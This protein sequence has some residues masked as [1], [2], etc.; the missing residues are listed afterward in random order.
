M[1][2]YDFIVIGSGPAGS[3]CSRLLSENNFKVLLLEKYKTPRK[4]P[5]AG[6]LS[7]HI[8]KLLDFDITETIDSIS[9]STKFTFR[10]KKPVFL[11]NPEVEIKM[12]NRD[13]FDFYLIKKAIESGVEF[14]DN[15]E[16]KKVIEQTNKVQVNTKSEN[17]TANYVI[18]ADGPYS[19]TARSLGLLKDRKT[20]WA[21]N[22]EVFVSD[23]QLKN[24]G[25]T[26][27]V[28]LGLIPS[29][30]AWIFPKKNR[31]SCGIGTNLHKIKNFKQMLFD[32][33][34]KNANTKNFQNIEISG[35]PLPYSYSNKLKIN[36]KHCVLIGDAASLVEPLSGEGIHY[37]MT[38]AKIAVKHLLYN[39]QTGASLDFYSEEINNTVRADLFYAE[40]FANL[41]H[42]FPKLVYSLGVSNKNVNSL[43]MDLIIGKTSYKEMYFYLKP[44]FS[45][46]FIKSKIKNNTKKMLNKIK[47]KLT[48]ND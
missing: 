17:F 3:T 22:A 32:Y 14:K 6:G 13:K 21:I 18:G 27:N 48:N 20:G 15:L 4:K 30:Y 36:T 1:K 9:V 37:A 31:L 39:I 44:K 16:V 28:D 41:L 12:T 40:K 29:G 45:G 43:F 8:N 42:K 46:K 24:Q 11:N 7:Y 2:H 34:N 10:H 26:V 25:N 19:I 23:K 35:H 38:S 33:L 5:C 47:N